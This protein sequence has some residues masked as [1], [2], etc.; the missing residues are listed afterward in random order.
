[1]VLPPGQGGP[2]GAVPL[3]GVIGDLALAGDTNC[4]RAVISI[5][6]VIDGL[7]VWA[8]KR[9]SGHWH[10]RCKSGS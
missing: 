9:L 6:G 5:I 1:V 4:G 3:V 2:C 8:G 10:S 7:A